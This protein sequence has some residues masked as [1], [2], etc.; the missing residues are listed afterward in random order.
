MNK[1]V[2]AGKKNKHLVNMILSI[3]NE[4]I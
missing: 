4:I 2:R 1:H 3:K